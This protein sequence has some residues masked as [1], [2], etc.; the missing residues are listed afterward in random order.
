MTKLPLLIAT[1]VVL[2]SS[3]SS[4]AAPEKV[5]YT[6]TGGNDGRNPYAGLILDDSGNL[7]GTTIYGGAYTYGTVF[8]LSRGA[9]GQWNETVLHSFNLDGHDGGVPYA[10]LV[11]DAAGNLYGTTIFGGASGT[12]CGGF[13]CGT[14][15]QLTTGTNGMWTERVLHSFSDNGNDGNT[16]YANLIFDRQGNLFGTTEYGGRGGG[17]GT[18]FELLRNAS[19]E[20]R[21]KIIHSFNYTNG[22]EPLGGLAFDSTGNLYGTTQ[23]GGRFTHGTVFELKLQP[24]GSWVEQVLHSFNPGSGVDGFAPYCGLVI[25]KLGNL[26]GTTADGGDFDH[27]TVFELTK[28]N[29]KWRERI[30]HSFSDYRDG[31]Y[32]YGPLAIDAADR[33]YGT[34]ETS[35]VKNQDGSGSVFRFSRR[36]KAYGW[37]ETILHQFLNAG[38]GAYPY[39]SVVLD[40]T[41]NIYGTTFGGG[42]SQG[43]GVVFEVEP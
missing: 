17:V 23:Y 11:R 7:Y 14:V 39:S 28:A 16:P 38:D 10:S 25:D 31:G 24:N 29:G 8:E 19:G 12:D 26:Y 33:I 2:V 21:E 4:W 15:F 22:G 42:D 13:G 1:L 5:L 32:P 6:F 35:S 37:Q 43:D 27:G 9:N 18:V 3:V 30:I 40:S 20:W 36:A 34:T 41:G